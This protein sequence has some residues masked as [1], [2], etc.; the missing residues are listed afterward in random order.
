M[1]TTV[2]ELFLNTILLERDE[3]S[4]AE[5]SMKTIKNERGR[6][7]DYDLYYNKIIIFKLIKKNIRFNL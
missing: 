3:A 5:R 7:E 4:E 2:F 6:L 1:V